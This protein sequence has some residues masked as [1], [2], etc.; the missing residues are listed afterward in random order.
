MNSE[1]KSMNFVF[2]K[3]FTCKKSSK[4]KVIIFQNKARQQSTTMENISFR[5]SIVSVL[6]QDEEYTVKYNPL[7]EGWVSFF[8]PERLGDFFVLRG[9]VIFFPLEVG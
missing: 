4:L 9:L 3:R 1:V 2:F 6:G 8:G 5:G 7:P